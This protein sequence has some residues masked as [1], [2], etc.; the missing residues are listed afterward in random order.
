VSDG[1]GGVSV[2]TVPNVKIVLPN[3]VEEPHGNMPGYALKVISGCAVGVRSGVGAGISSLSSAEA[4]DAKI[5][6]GTIKIPD[7]R[8]I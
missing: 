6:K 1:G 3:L 5:V 4:F 7:N 8:I 2:T